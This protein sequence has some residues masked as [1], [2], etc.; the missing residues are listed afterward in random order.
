MSEPA[1]MTAK[2]RPTMKR[3][4]KKRFDFENLDEEG[5][6]TLIDEVEIPEVRKVPYCSGY[7]DEWCLTMNHGVASKCDPFAEYTQTSYA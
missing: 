1:W 2:V 6:P 7:N 4:T 3:K 5:Y